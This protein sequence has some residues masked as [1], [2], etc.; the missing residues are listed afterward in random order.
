MTFQKGHPFYKGNEKQGFKKGQHISPNTE[1]K[2]GHISLMKGIPRSENTKLK[3]SS[4]LKGH[5]LSEETIQKIRL[6]NIG[7]HNYSNETKQKIR[8]SKLGVKRKPFS[9]EWKHNISLS[10][11]GK[12]AG[13]KNPAKR[14]EVREK[15]SLN[16]LGKSVWNKGKTGIYSEE[17]IRKMRLGHL[18]K[19]SPNKGK[20]LSP[21]SEETKQKMR[22]A[23]KKRYP[24]PI[25]MQQQMK[26]MRAKL[27]IP[28]KDT[29]IEVKIQNFLKQLGI[30][31]FTHQYIKEIKHG[32]QC[33]IYIPAMNMV[34]ECDGLYWHKYPTGRDIDRVRTSELISKGFK[35]LRLWEHEIKAMNLEQFKERLQ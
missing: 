17:T 30:Q 7:K 23:M 33:D 11:K 20:K 12:L 32:Y 24:N 22:E 2:K 8:L 18:G 13:D 25:E 19:P 6:S 5:Q 14:P 1:F 21:F 10:H 16:H 34:I 9:E 31:F 15:M 26:Q 28:K 4:T 3:I 29:K 35:V 27:I